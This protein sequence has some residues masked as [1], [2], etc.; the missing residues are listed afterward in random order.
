MNQEQVL[1]AL[2]QRRPGFSLPADFYL[3]PSIFEMEMKAIFETQWLLAGNACEIPEVGDYLV[4]GIGQNSIIVL[5]SED[6]FKAFYNS[7]RHRGSRL[8]D[9]DKGHLNKIVCPYHHW[10]YGLSGEL[11][12]ASDMGEDFRLSDYPLKPVHLKDICGLLYVSLGE[13]PP[14]L[15]YFSDTVSA[16][17]APHQPARTK[18]ACEISLL[19][20]ANWKLVIENNRECYHCEGNH[21]ELLHSLTSFALP[22]DPTGT[23]EFHDLMRRKTRDWDALGLSHRPAD[24]LGKFRCIRLPF[25]NDALTMSLDGGLLSR[26]LLGDLTDPDLGSVRM[27]HVPGNW[28]H[29]ASDHIIHF[30]VHP[31]SASQTRVTTKW[32]VHEDAIEGWDYDVDQ[33]TAVWRATNDQDR[34][35]AENNFRGI[36]NKGYEPG[37]YSPTSEFMCIDFIDWYSEQLLSQAQRPAGR[38]IPIAA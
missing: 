2:R 7:C 23:G 37:P 32:L 24:G 14:D 17:I 12:H 11:Q 8:C 22:D 15:D 5:R 16:Y 9:K 1:S 21:P 34:R 36:R 38:V 3:D 28:N 25:V 18:V 33:L 6:G 20:E 13:S 29:F 27:F 4:A 19:E 31:L 26:R 35:L 10:T 30:T